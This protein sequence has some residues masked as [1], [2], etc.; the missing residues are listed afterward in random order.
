MATSLAPSASVSQ[1]GLITAGSTTPGQF[2]Q[3]Q[4]QILD[5]LHIPIALTDRS[6]MKN[7]SLQ[8]SFTRYKAVVWA[9]TTYKDLVFKGTWKE[10]GLPKLRDVEIIEFCVGHTLWYNHW[11]QNFAGVSAYDDMLNWLENAPDRLSDLDLWELSHPLYNQ[12]H[13]KTWLQNKGTLSPKKPKKEK[14][15]Q[16]EVDKASGSK[17][18]DKHRKSKSSSSKR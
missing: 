6:D 11:S 16:K 4:L 3:Q 5:L 1:A 18:E 12:K 13:L 2:S 14:G 7:L 15:K 17:K 10:L 8:K 9:Q